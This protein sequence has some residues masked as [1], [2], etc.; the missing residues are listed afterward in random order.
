MGLQQIFIG[1]ANFYCHFIQGFYRIATS[2]TAMLKRTGS[3]V[4]SASRADDNEV[5][6]GG[7]ARAESGGSVDGL[8]ASRKKSTKSKSQTKSG[9]NCTEYTEDE[10][11]VHSSRRPQR[12]GLIA[13]EAPI[14]VSVEYA[15]FAN[16]FSLDLAFELPE[17]NGINNHPIG[18]VDNFPSDPPVLQYLLSKRRKVAFGYASE[19]S[20]T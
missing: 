9:L 18:L 19:V 5:V 13:K 14:K 10:E 11:D 6:G 17:H 16:V 2:L 3:S 15:D 1:F 20:I 7:D 4:A 12:A 8:D